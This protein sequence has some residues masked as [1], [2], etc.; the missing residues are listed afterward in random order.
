MRDDFSFDTFRSSEYQ[1]MIRKTKEGRIRL[2]Q[3]AQQVGRLTSGNEETKS[4]QTAITVDERLNSVDPAR[5][6]AEE[7][8]RREAEEVQQA[9]AQGVNPLQVSKEGLERAN[10]ILNGITGVL[11]NLTEAQVDMTLEELLS[12]E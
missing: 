9:N 10:L 8:A 7:K 12:E 6:E 11:P 2:R 5:R 4:A 3:L 1:E